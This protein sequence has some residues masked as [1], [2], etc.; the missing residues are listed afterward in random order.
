MTLLPSA[1][2][3][4]VPFVYASLSSL[5][6]TSP[7]ILDASNCPS[8]NTR[9]LWDIL[10]SCGLTLFAC[11]WTAVHPNIPG[12]DEGKIAITSRRLFIM[13]M[14][15]IAPEL[16]I[17]WATRQFFSARWTITHGFF[18]WMGGF[19]LY[20]DGMPR[21]TLTPDELLEF[22]RRGSVDMPVIT[23]AEMEDRSKGDG[24]SKGIAILQLVWFVAQLVAR[25]I[26]NLPITLLE[27]DTLA[28]AALTC[29]PYALW[30]KKPKD[31]G[32]PYIVHLKATAAPPGQLRYEKFSHISR[33]YYRRIR[34]H[35]IYP[36]VCLMGIAVDP[37]PR[38]ARSRRVPSLGG[39]DRGFVF[40]FDH[41][42][43]PL[44]RYRVGKI[45]LLIGCFSGMVFGGIHCLGWNHFSTAMQS[46]LWRT[47]SL[48]V[49]C[50]PVVISLDTLSFMHR[51]RPLMMIF[52]F[53]PGHIAALIYIT[54]RITLI[55]LIIL[56]L[57]SL[58]TGVYD[59]VAWTRFIPHL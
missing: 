43:G 20:V 52:G 33:S 32:R 42:G 1:V 19:M 12:M 50:A 14:A 22:V 11:T 6:N 27:I 41:N 34:G 3:L 10:L 55:V 9:S 4:C 25:Y 17:T 58:P 18:A 53:L 38:A 15:L 48:L 54:A 49:I 47:T 39:Y 40:K 29:I 26:Q 5:N 30:W 59:T 35:I 56:S 37:S 16:M 51:R 21:A 31:V 24:L 36:F 13:A 44:T 23:E 2:L 28:V 57:Q 46:T 7:H 45:V 8:C